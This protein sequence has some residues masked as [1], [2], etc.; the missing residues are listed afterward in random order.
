MYFPLK[1]IISRTPRARYS[2]SLSDI[3]IPSSD[4]SSPNHIFNYLDRLGVRVTGKFQWSSLYTCFYPEF[5]YPGTRYISWLHDMYS[6]FCSSSTSNKVYTVDTFERKKGWTSEGCID[7]EKFR[8]SS[9]LDL[10]NTLF[11]DLSLAVVLRYSQEQ[12]M[13]FFLLKPFQT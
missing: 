10:V 2:E 4:L 11:H 13:T 1:H 5:T 6:C 3:P 7:N 9:Q 8:R 12:P